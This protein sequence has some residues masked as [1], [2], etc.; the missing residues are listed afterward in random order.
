MPHLDER[1]VELLAHPFYQRQLGPWGGRPRRR[2]VRPDEDGCLVFQGAVN[3]KGYG[4]VGEGLMHRLAWI[5]FNGPIPHGNELHHTCRRKLCCRIDHLA[6]L[7]KS[8]H[9]ALEAR[10]Q[11]LD[12][13][14]VISILD[15]LA[16]GS[17]RSNVARE[18][19]VSTTTVA[20]VQA[21]RSWRRVVA[22]YRAS[23]GRL[24]SAA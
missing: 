6:C 3:S 18:F 21:G 19:G 17:S 11:K 10:P 8:E 16:T 12:E 20:D 13:S 9:A 24:R 5:A 15:R 1:I 4:C 23:E 2:C 22:H 14:R 7:T